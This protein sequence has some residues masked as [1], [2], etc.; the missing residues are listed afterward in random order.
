MSDHPRIQFRTL[1]QCSCGARG[2][3]VWE[4]NDEVSPEGPMGRL[5]G[6]SDGFRYHVAQGLPEVVCTTCNRVLLD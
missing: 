2:D 5:V 6:I 1:L 3:A 4:E